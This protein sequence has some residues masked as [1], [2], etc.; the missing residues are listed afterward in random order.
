MTDLADLRERMARIETGQDA[1]RDMLRESLTDLRPRVSRLE[2][3]QWMQAGGVGVVTFLLA[4]FG[5]PDF[6]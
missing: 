1:M 2:R 6:R 3:R 5:I 4:K